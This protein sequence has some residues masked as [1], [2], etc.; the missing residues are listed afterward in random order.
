M[1]TRSIY[2]L[3]L[4]IASFATISC[5]KESALTDEPA[6][7]VPE[8]PVI[9]EKPTV[10]DTVVVALGYDL[11][12]TEENLV[13]SRSG[14]NDLIGVQIAQF[15]KGVLEDDGVPYACGVFDDIDAM[16]FKMVKGNKY[17]ITMNYLPNGKNI[18]YNYPNGSYGYP[19]SARFGYKN[20]KLNDITYDTGKPHVDGYEGEVLSYLGVSGYQ[21]NSSDLFRESFVVGTT[22][23][24]LGFIDKFILAEDAQIVMP[25][26][27]YVAAVKL[28]IGNFDKG[29]IRMILGGTSELIKEFVPGDTLEQSFWIEGIPVGGISRGLNDTEWKT[30]TIYYTDEKHQ[31]FLL[32]TKSLQFKKGTKYVFN[33]DL[34]ERAD[35]SIGIQIINNDLVEENSTFD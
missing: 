18:V 21:N 17:N 15:R 23:R 5:S 19:F 11:N 30:I 24:Y 10:N 32:A 8:E 9:P 28:N 31:T 6:P 12:M 34:Q 33:F 26:E 7:I 13:T 2:F 4:L 3:T 16:K 29:K 35:G 1:K 22:P 25:L 27:L 20:Y 14:G